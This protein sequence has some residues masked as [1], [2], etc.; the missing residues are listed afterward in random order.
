VLT[1]GLPRVIADEAT[2]TAHGNLQF[3]VPAATARHATAEEY[4]KKLQEA[5]ALILA[6]PPRSGLSKQAV[7]EL[8]RIRAP[9]LRIVSCDPPT[10]ARDLHALLAAGYRI[11]R[12]ALVDFFPQTSH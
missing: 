4:L 7:A 8:I 10:L 5:P 9:Q 12:L 11:D 1:D 3:N 6:D 2:A